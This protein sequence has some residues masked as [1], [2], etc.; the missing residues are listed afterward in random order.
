M[1]VPGLSRRS[2]LASAS[3][4]AALQGVGAEAR[5]A[6]AAPTTRTRRAYGSCV[7][8]QVH[9]RIAEPA[10]RARKPPL[11]C[12]H[13][14]PASGDAFREFQNVMARGRMVVCP[15][16]P[17]YGGSDA[18]P[19]PPTMADYGAATRAALKTAGIAGPVDL[20]GFHTG[21][22]VAMEMA[23]QNPASVRRLVMPAIPYYPAQAR[24]EKRTQFAQPRPL[25]DDPGYLARNWKETVLDRR[26][27]GVSQE[28]HLDLFVERLRAG[29]RSWYGF[30]AVFRY[31]ADSR[32]AAL[33]HPVLCPI[34]NETLAE[35][36]RAAAR[37][38][39]HVTVTECM[40][41]DG[42][43]WQAQPER[44]VAAIAPFLDA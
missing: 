17:G 4:A 30:D 25:F 23:L 10:G 19:A 27:P 1:T 33:T 37:L 43:A 26:V 11:V 38:I 8:G 2:V 12:L 29:T 44:L 20:L 28:R 34:L 39:P 22:F 35:P 24:A 42:W 7:Y 21:N 31:D 14:S 36:T 32:L 15:D 18:P 13:Q 6:E 5:S 9:M 16:M 3:G 40:D 41:L